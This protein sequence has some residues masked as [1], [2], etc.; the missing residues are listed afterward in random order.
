MT[1][2]NQQPTM[3]ASSLPSGEGGGR[4]PFKRC[5]KCG[6]EKPLDEFYKFEGLRSH[7]KVDSYCKQCRQKQ[8]AKARA[9]RRAKL[10]AEREAA[11]ALIPEGYKVCYTCKQLL[12]YSSFS[13]YKSSKDGHRG[14]CRKCI[15]EYTK[16]R[17]VKKSGIFRGDD[18]RL[19]QYNGKSRAGFYWTPDMI[20]VLKRYYPT[21][22][23]S[24]VAEMLG[25]NADT[26]YRK[27]REL[28]I[29]KSISYLS[30]CSREAQFYSTCSRNK[31][32]RKQLQPKP[33]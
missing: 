16:S 10:R 20:S 30:Q 31:N 7:Q 15:S 14:S 29:G 6:E 12:P 1:N 26:V 22:P 3:P 4:G 9:R 32:K 11:K 23:T 19:Y 18:G 2:N 28:G 33:L 25:M 8:S 5:S 13:L 17:R 24:E 21:N 27:A